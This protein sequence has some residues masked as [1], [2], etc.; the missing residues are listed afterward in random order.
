M[1]KWN[2]ARPDAAVSDDIASLVDLD[3]LAVEVLV[4]RGYK[5]IDSFADFFNSC[6]LEDPFVIKDMREAADTIIKAVD[7]YELICIYGDYDCDG[8]TSTAVLYD[9]LISIGANAM[10]YIPER[11]DGYGLNSNAVRYLHDQGVSLIVTVDNGISAYKEAEE[12]YELGMKLVVTDHHQPGEY[13]PKAEAI[14]DP[15]REDCPS[16]FKH[17]CGCGVVLKLC[18]A[19]DDGSYDMVTE[20]YLDICALATIADVVSLTGENRYIVRHGLKQINNTSNYGLRALK[21][22]AGCGDEL[23]ASDV[24]FMLSPRI[25]ASGRFGSPVTAVKTLLAEEDDAEVYAGMLANLNAQRKQTEADISKEIFEYINTCPEM[26]NERVLILYGKGWSH[27]VIGIVAARIMEFYGK[28]AVIISEEGGEARGSARSIKGFNI[29]KCFQYCGDLLVKYGGHECAAGL[30]IMPDKLEEFKARVR[31]YA[32]QF[33]QMPALT[34]DADKL[35]KPSD[36]T[37]QH[38]KGLDRIEPCGEG[39]PQPVFA[40]TGAQVTGVYPLKNGKHSRIQI[41]YGGVNA[42]AVMWNISPDKLPVYKNSRADMIVTLDVNTYNGNESVSLKVLD[43]R[44]SGF[45]QNAYFSAKDCYEKIKRNE[46]VP[47]SFIKKVTPSREE[48]VSVYKA[49]KA[50]GSIN[51]DSLYFKFDPKVMNY[52]KLRLCI[53]IFCELALMTFKAGSGI[54]SVTDFKG[55]ADITSAPMLLHLKELQSAD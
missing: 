38:I 37:V 17:L 44:P 8:V 31:E 50:A 10:Y 28:P 18:A 26:L 4:A 55:K 49:V 15:H 16:A 3:K 24:A 25:N 5:D 41:N 21:E 46:K 51:A 29:F 12:I 9:Y 42:S 19:L 39:N 47:A 32:A 20:Q 34:I 33:E 48:L 23:K 30:T 6:E 27:G 52:C 13:L 54:V 36:L 11:A 40:I 7:D 35:L 45:N 43:I 22:A 1:K 53:D 2:I 14:V